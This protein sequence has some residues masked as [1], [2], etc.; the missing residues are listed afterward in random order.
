MQQTGGKGHIKQISTSR[1]KYVGL[2]YTKIVKKSWWEEETLRVRKLLGS[3]EKCTPGYCVLGSLTT[4]LLHNP[5]Q[6]E[7][8]QMCKCVYKRKNYAADQHLLST[9]ENT[10][11]GTSMWSEHQRWS[12]K[13]LLS[14]YVINW[15]E[16]IINFDL[17]LKQTQI[18]VSITIIS[19]HN[20]C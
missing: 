9:S 5:R 3:F 14:I 6:L 13:T 17:L 19:I 11:L 10:V 16:S 7:N 4:C 1:K 8:V 2:L 20:F 18:K 12:P 15:L